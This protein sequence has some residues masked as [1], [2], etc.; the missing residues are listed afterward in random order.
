[1]GKHIQRRGF[2]CR[3]SSP[4]CERRIPFLDRMIKEC[5]VLSYPPKSPGSAFER[6]AP[7]LEYRNGLF[8]GQSTRDLSSSNTSYGRQDRSSEP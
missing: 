1:M 6:L 4:L 3:H 7:G 5:P 2:Y 8:S